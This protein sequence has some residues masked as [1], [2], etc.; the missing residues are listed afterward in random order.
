MRMD[1]RPPRKL[2]EAAAIR[3]FAG[4]AGVVVLSG[5]LG[6]ASP[7]APED[8][9]PDASQSADACT[10]C[11]VA[12]PPGDVSSGVEDGGGSEGPTGLPVVNRGDPAAAARGARI[13]F[14]DWPGQGLIPELA[15][16]HLYLVWTDNLLDVYGY[17]TNADRY[18]ADFRLRYGMH[19]APDGGLPLGLRSTGDGKATVTCLICHAGRSP[20]GAVVIGLPN[21]DL[22]LQGFYDELWR[23]PAAFEALKARD[24]PQ[25][26]KGL[27]AGIP[28]P[29]LPAPIPGMT[30]RTGAPGATDAMGLG[31]QFGAIALGKD[32]SEIQTRFGFQNPSAWWTVA[33]KPRRY[34]DGSVPFGGHRTMMATLLGVGLSAEQLLAVE[35]RF[36]DVEQYLTTIAPPAW[37]F[38]PPGDV[39]AGRAVFR[40]HCSECHGVYEGEERSYP[41]RVVPVAELGTDPLRAERFG[42]DEAAVANGLIMDPEH[43]MTPTGGYLAPPLTAVWATAPY[44]HN[45][46][47]PDVA[48]VLDSASRP[49]RWRRTGD[50]DSQRLGLAYEPVEG[51]GATELPTELLDRRTVETGVPG[52]S[53]GGH[54]YGDSLTA[55][56]RAAV[57]DYLKTL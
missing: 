57:L 46:A 9:V 37:P 17:Y 48:S 26:Y 11:D 30:D 8:A 49:A 31:I 36:D 24:L 40:E 14:E 27:V 25:P 43:R 22:D 18:W 42:A 20:D 38:E 1:G 33:L 13:F 53:R 6:C 39:S 50:Y 29:P 45:G 41:A 2:R 15:L 5:V 44:L 28:V 32:P 10:V 3:G 47:V 7:S 55:E 4:L 35:P 54:L 51:D 56:E 12:Q 34:W 16:R 19:E 52:L 21:A 23:L